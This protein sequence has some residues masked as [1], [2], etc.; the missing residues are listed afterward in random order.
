MTLQLVELS[1]IILGD[2]IDAKHGDFNHELSKVWNGAL[3]EYKVL[4]FVKV[5]D[6]FDVAKT[7]KFCDNYNVSI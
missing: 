7:L 5:K 6:K 1:D 4:A 2:V 3:W